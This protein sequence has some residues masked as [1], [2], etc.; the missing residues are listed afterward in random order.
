MAQERL[1]A[2]DFRQRAFD[3]DF[4]PAGLPVGK[5]VNQVAHQAV[6]IHRL[7]RHF[8][9]EKFGIAQDVL[10]Q[11]VEPD[12]RAHDPV[13]VFKSLFIEQAAVIIR[14]ELSE[15]LH[16]AQRRA[17]V[18]RYAVRKPFQFA[19]RF[20]QLTGAFLDDALQFEG[21]LGDFIPG[22]HQGLLRPSSS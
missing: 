9:V 2:H 12:G 4:G 21:V 5:A 6:Q 1:V 3:L 22:G 18:V 10:D 19:N 14:Q 7:H 8:A 17:H 11:T 13:Q 20:A 15:A 16:G